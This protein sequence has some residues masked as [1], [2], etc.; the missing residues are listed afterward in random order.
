MNII[1]FN[2]FQHTKSIFNHGFSM[3]G[4]SPIFISLPTKSILDFFGVILLGGAWWRCTYSTGLKS[5]S[6]WLWNVQGNFVRHTESLSLVGDNVTIKR[7][8]TISISTIRCA[9]GC[10]AYTCVCVNKQ[11]LV[12]LEQPSFFAKLLAIK[13]LKWK[14]NKNQLL[15]I[16]RTEVEGRQGC[17]K[18]KNIEFKTY[19]NTR[20]AR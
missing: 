5:H 18:Q 20:C 3:G 11:P 7:M 8:R 15:L 13:T 16:T 2:N 9:K 17:N 6:S 14:D 10:N 1:F 4:I 12:M 19:N